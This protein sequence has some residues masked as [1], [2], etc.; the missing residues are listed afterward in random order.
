MD[1]IGC[2]RANQSD[3]GSGALKLHGKCDI[4]HMVVIGAAGMMAL[5]VVICLTYILGCQCQ[6]ICQLDIEAGIPAGLLEPGEAV[7]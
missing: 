6:V 1:G 5:V 2:C 7:S 3:D 4:Y